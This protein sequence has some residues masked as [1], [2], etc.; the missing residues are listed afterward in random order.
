MQAAPQQLWPSRRSRL[1]RGPTRR[2]TPIAAVLAFAFA[3]A[4][5]ACGGSATP[6][7]GQATPPATATAASGAGTATS[8]PTNGAAPIFAVPTVEPTPAAA[9]K[10][11]A[12]ATPAASPAAGKGRQ[13]VPAN[14]QQVVQAFQRR[15]IPIGQVQNLSASDDPDHLLG[16][17]GG[18]TS[19][20]VFADSRVANGAA[21]SVQAGGAVEFFANERDAQR[22]FAQLRAAQKDSAQPEWL[23]HDGNVVLRLS[24][25]LRADQ[26]SEYEIGARQALAG[27]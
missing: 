5:T 18:Y 20:S 16:A 8:A 10:R 17:P 2:R 25:A 6:K 15:G 1:R 11:N 9:G 23:F 13:P 7:R 21:P 27:R 3:L 19:K 24:A 12:R 22:R 14:A 4:L 26:A